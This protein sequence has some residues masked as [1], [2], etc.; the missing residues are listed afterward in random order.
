[1]KD[2]TM[3]LDM[4]GVIVNTIEGFESRLM[5]MFPEVEP[6]PYEKLSTFYIENLY[7]EEHREKIAKVWESEGLFYGLK[8][9]PGAIE[10]IEE[11]RRRVK[12]VVICTSPRIESKY[13]VQEKYEWVRE[14][15][16]QDW[17]KRL[18]IAKD[19]TRIQGDILI[20]DKP[21]IR[22]ERI[23]SWEQVL[24]THPWNSEVTHLRRL[25]WENWEEILIELR[26]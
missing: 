22:G 3:I 11:I 17:L 8:P 16:N 14:N 6:V 4:D 25:T 23:P 10:A 7:P 19:K 12:D 24:Y 9:L 20:D 13:C 15:L 2:M 21:K 26:Q 1:M 5:E 18:I